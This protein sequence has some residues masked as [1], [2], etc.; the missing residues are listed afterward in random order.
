MRV[1]V[2]IPA[3]NEQ[4]TVAHVV[5]ACLASQAHEVVVVD[6]DSTDATAS[7]A[8]E[9][10]ARVINW[11]DVYP[12]L[13]PRP[14]KGEALWRGVKAA[15]GD[16]VVFIDA[17]VTSVE[18]R[19]VDTLAA[20]FVDAGIHLVK[21]SY[22]RDLG[23]VA[24]G[25]GRVTELTAK[26]LLRALFPELADITQPLAGEYAIRRDTALELPFVD[27]YGVEAGLLLDVAATHGREAISQVELGARQHRNRPLTEL[28]P[29]ADVVAAT[30]LQRAGVESAGVGQRSPWASVRM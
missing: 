11:A 17:D 18:A 5:A 8:R 15:S 3:L 26:P 4:D 13:P 2:V 14:G 25:G 12:Q 10:G 16:V 22:R 23:A 20:P 24:G 7:R 21:A 1:S 29:M 27:G 6:S 30:I 28:G 9:A 19:W